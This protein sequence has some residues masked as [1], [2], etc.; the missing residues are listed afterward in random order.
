KLVFKV[1][2]STTLLLPAWKDTV[3]ND[4]DLE[5]RLILCDVIT[6]WNSTYDMLM[7]VLEYRGVVE[8]FTANHKNDVHELELSDEEWSIV[9]SPFPYLTTPFLFPY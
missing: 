1:I 8:K 4:D 2:N 7:F 3:A 9:S 5:D 6:Q